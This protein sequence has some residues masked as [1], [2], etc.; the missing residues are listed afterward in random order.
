VPP[1]RLTPFTAGMLALPATSPEPAP[2]GAAGSG[3]ASSGG[4]AVT[5]R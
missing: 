2:D 5:P 4:A 3:G 1:A